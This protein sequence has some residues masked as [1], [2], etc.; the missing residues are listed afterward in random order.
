M[1]SVTLDCPEALREAPL[2]QESAR[3]T[4]SLNSQQR[5]LCGVVAALSC[6]GRVALRRIDIRVESQ[7]ITL[8]GQVRSFYLKQLA[9]HVASSVTGV[10]SVDN[11]LVVEGDRS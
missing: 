2:A 8:N 1:W 7:R 6:S 4:A 11:R 10:S 5:L 9:Q 3:E